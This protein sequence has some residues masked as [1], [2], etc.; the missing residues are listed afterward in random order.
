MLRQSRILISTLALGGFMA[1]ATSAFAAETKPFVQSQFDAD[2]AA[3]Q[4]I[5]VKVTAPWCP[6][7]KAQK[8]ILDGELAQPK[9]SK[10][11]VYEVD[12]DSQKEALRTL[13]VRMQSTLITYKA[14][15]ETGRSTG[16]TNKASVTGLLDKA[17]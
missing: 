12:F 15:K 7:C 1:L 6:T 14:G 3:G 8:V 13:D 17:L 16:D 9:F 5:L 10:L 4:S 11:K 2:K